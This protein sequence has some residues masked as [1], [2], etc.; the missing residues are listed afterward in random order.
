MGAP[1]QLAK[2]VFAEEVPRLFGDKVTWQTGTELSLTE[3]RLD[4]VLGVRAPLDLALLPAP[5]C[6]LGDR[7][8]AVEV[9][10]P[11]DH[12]T[13]VALQRGLL[14][15]QALQVALAERDPPHET[16]AG[17][18]LIAPHLPKLVRERCRPEAVA[19]GCYQLGLGNFETLWVAANELPLHESLWP[20]LVARSGLPLVEML[21]WSMGRQPADWVSRVL[22]H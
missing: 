8:T 15:R 14:R 11:G 5:W 13:W 6:F 9:K 22:N 18:W 3:V 19:P 1:D 4:G 2:E 10:M 12:L 16:L 7:V 21:Q 17:L 20:F